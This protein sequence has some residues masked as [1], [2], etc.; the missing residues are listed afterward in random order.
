[1][2]RRR[3][4]GK[5]RQAVAPPGGPNQ[6]CGEVPNN[7]EMSPEGRLGTLECL[8]TSSFIDQ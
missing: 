4:I 1:M 7:L 2:S 6:F 8:K 3:P 5:R